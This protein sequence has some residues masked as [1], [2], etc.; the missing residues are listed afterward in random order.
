MQKLAAAVLSA[1]L[2]S[3]ASLAAFQRDILYVPD[4][5]HVPPA[6]AGL[7]QAEELRLS[8]SDG[9]S[10][11]AW[12]VAPQPGRPVLLYFHGN[13]GALA[14]RVARFKLFLEKGY[15]LLGLSYRG[16][17]GST[18]APTQAGLFTDGET[19]YAEA[20]RRY[21][22]SRIVIVGESLGTGVAVQIAA[23]HESAGVLLDA[24]FLSA[25]DVAEY[26][27]PIF[28]VRYL[29]LDPFRSDIAIRAL[30]RP[31]LIAHGEA[32]A[33]V[34]FASGQRLFAQAKEPKTFI[35]VP[36]EGHLVLGKRHVFAAAAA[37][38]ETVA[39]LTR[40]RAEPDP[41]Q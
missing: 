31:L 3:M 38:I 37:W 15:G 4:T 9:E 12:H 8:T 19:A 6:A 22:P 30:R 5:R 21:D 34:P 28:P 32:D 24:P 20:A 39:G 17:G 1:Y 25:L 13:S 29:M 33:I 26:R 18:G 23:R 41:A 40:A 10:L 2:A 36:G 7:P 35:A 11:V 27:Y 16:Y 14:D